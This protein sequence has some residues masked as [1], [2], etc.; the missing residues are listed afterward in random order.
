M[1]H[2]MNYRYDDCGGYFTATKGNV[3]SP[4]YPNKYPKNANCLYTIS[5]PTG[6]Y[7]T[8]NILSMDIEYGDPEYYEYNYYT[9][10]DYHQFAGVT[11]WDYL[12]IRDG[13]SEH[14]ALIDGYCGD[15]TVLSLP[16][17]IQSTQNHVWMRYEGSIMRREEQML[18]LLSGS[19]LM[20]GDQMGMDFL[21]STQQ[22]THELVKLDERNKRIDPFSGC[23]Y[24]S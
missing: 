12:E 7:I 1:A 14:S 16:L 24:C 21:L 6:T 2:R 5:A 3:T 22:W 11:C 17:L 23:V 9:D 10:S 15:N 8:M 4:S 18:T 13:A 20:V 19:T